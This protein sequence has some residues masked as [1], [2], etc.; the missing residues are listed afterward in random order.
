M[1]FPHRCLSIH[2][3][4]SDR[5]VSSSHWRFSSFNLLFW[6]E[7][8]QNLSFFEDCN[9]FLLRFLNFCK[10]SR[11]IKTFKFLKPSRSNFK[12]FFDDWSFWEN[13]HFRSIDERHKKATKWI[14]INYHPHFRDWRSWRFFNS[15]KIKIKMKS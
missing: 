5:R 12:S 14:K 8:V 2:W 9:A 1:C 13:P 4:S 11:K 6:Q 3:F 7:F 10:T 15:A